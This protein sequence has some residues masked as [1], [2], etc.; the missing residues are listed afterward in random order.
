ML[1]F[2]RAKKMYNILDLNNNPSGHTTLALGSLMTKELLRVG[3]GDDCERL[4]FVKRLLP[5]FRLLPLPNSLHDLMEIFEQIMNEQSQTFNEILIF[6]RKQLQVME[7]LMQLPSKFGL[8]P[9][10]MVTFLKSQINLL[11]SM[12]DDVSESS[13]SLQRHTVTE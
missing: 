8:P 2:Q 10:S 9:L 4:T 1:D 12:L 13:N 6:R 3:I 5:I 11:K 7:I